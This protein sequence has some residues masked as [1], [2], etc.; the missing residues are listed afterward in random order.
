MLGRDLAGL[1]GEPPGRINEEGGEA[2]FAS[3]NEQIPIDAG[4]LS[5]T[6]ARGAGV[7]ESYR[8]PSAGSWRRRFRARS[9]V[10]QTVPEMFPTP[11]TRLA[12]KIA[13]SMSAA[14]RE[15]TARLIA[16]PYV[17]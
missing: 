9:T 2:A 5:V 3:E 14:S 7:R 8:T 10:P 6:A 15:R 1:V 12:S 13:A 17:D 16:S 4:P 11:A